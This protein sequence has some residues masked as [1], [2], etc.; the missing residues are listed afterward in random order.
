METYDN[1][2]ADEPSASPTGWRGANHASPADD[3]ANEGA[4]KQPDDLLAFDAI[5]ALAP[6]ADQPGLANLEAQL[7]L[8]LAER[9][10]ATPDVA[11]AWA[12]WAARLDT[13]AVALTPVAA[14][15]ATTQTSSTGPVI[16]ET[17]MIEERNET[18]RVIGAI[19][20]PV[21]PDSSSPAATSRG[22]ARKRLG[23][24]GMALAG[25][26]AVLVA[27]ALVGAGYGAA[28][29]FG[30][31]APFANHELQLIGDAHLYTTINQTRTAQGVS[32]TIDKVYAD[33]G[34]TYIAYH[35]SGVT[36]ATRD[37]NYFVWASF[38]VADQTS[39]QPVGAGTACQEGPG[40]GG[41]QYCLLD[42]GP[43]HPAAGATMLTITIDI[44]TMFVQKAGSA[45]FIT[46][47]GDWS[48]QFTLPFHHKN[49]GS[50]GPYGGPTKTSGK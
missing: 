41:A 20:A 30:A 16:T 33:E 26:A 3:L 39:E 49:L 5:D 13:P 23:W 7:R 36:S 46:L 1:L 8:T 35:A 50:G 38:D 22:A 21:I 28:T 2:F 29:Y 48:F 34:A 40:N 27:A 47:H 10:P 42:M 43:F 18:P 19:G 4:G 12:T 32:V 9:A 11:S 17:T 24:R 44:H 25:L 31:P 15:S 45:Q 37:A 14:S 6:A